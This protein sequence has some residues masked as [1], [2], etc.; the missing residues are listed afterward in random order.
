MRV[1]VRFLVRSIPYNAGEIAVFEPDRADLLVSRGVA[2]LVVDTP[3]VVADVPAVVTAEAE[4]VGN[5]GDLEDETGA[6]RPTRRGRRR[7]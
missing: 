6:D 3:A 2:E 4:I 5:G 7:G 1:A